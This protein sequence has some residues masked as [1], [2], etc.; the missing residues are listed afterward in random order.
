MLFRS[1]AQAAQEMPATDPTAG[2]SSVGVGRV[3]ALPQADPIAA[4]HGRKGE[5]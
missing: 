1:A 4:R 5:A 3:V 2:D